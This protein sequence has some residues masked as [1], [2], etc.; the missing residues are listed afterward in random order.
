METVGL[1]LDL[2]VRK[3]PVQNINTEVYWRHKFAL[4]N[5]IFQMRRKPCIGAGYDSLLIGVFS[6]EYVLKKWQKN[7]QMVAD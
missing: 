1:G 4:K 7:R 6:C 2:K 5:S 3:M